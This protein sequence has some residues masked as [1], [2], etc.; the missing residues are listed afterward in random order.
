M[1]TITM[2]TNIDPVK[3]NINGVKYEYRA[4]ET[5]EVPDSVA[6]VIEN[7]I[8]NEPKTIPVDNFATEGYVDKA[9]ADA[10]IVD[11]DDEIPTMSGEGTATSQTGVPPTPVVPVT[12]G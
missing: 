4:G 7:I 8:A 3:I 5:Y 10:L 9:V 6:C 1:K 11:E 2:P 12:E